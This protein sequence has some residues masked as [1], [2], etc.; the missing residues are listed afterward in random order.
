MTSD[1]AL[2]VDEGH[3]VVGRDRDARHR[4]RRRCRAASRRRSPCRAASASSPLPGSPRT[5]VVPGEAPVEARLVVVGV[6]RP[7]CAARARGDGGRVGHLVDRRRR[8]RARCRRARG[9]RSPGRSIEPTTVAAVEV[10]GRQ[11]IR[12]GGHHVRA[13]VGHEQ[14]RRRDGRRSRARSARG[15]RRRRAAP[16]RSRSSVAMPPSS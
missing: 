13:V 5:T 16:I 3:A 11:P 6:G 1:A 7:G 15:R 12:R 10:D 14:V 9:R 2:R 4:R 8:A